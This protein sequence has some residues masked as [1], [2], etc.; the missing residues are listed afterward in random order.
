MNHGT[1]LACRNGVGARDALDIYSIKQRRKLVFC[2]STLDH[3]SKQQKT[4]DKQQ[5]A[6]G[7]SGGGV[8]WVAIHP[9]LWVI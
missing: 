3:F 2:K 4:F 8:D 5:N 6:R 7:G 9:H 1:S